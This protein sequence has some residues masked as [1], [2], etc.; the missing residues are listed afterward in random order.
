MIISFLLFVVLLD[1]ILL[2]VIYILH[3]RWQVHENILS[4]ITE[5]RQILAGMQKD[6]KEEAARFEAKTS[7]L[8]NKVNQIAAEIEQEAKQSKQTISAN[9]ESVVSEL[10]KQFEQPLRELV[11]RQQA[12]NGLYKKI[13]QEKEILATLLQRAES[14]IKFFEKDMA[15]EDILKDIEQK[16]YEDARKLLTKGL[17]V[18]S[19]AKQLGISASEV[20]L[21]QGISGI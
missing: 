13:S 19:V 5:E 4:D 11:T 20:R 8:L 18:E 16:K 10:S 15:Y 7:E 17:N 3:K 12:L 14:L 21:I 9:L 2:Y 1:A 6:I